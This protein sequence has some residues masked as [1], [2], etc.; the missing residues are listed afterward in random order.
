MSDIVYFLQIFIL[1]YSCSI[2][3]FN[4]NL[5]IF[6]KYCFYSISHLSFVLGLTTHCCKDKSTSWKKTPNHHHSYI[7]IK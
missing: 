6:Y 1:F 7:Y 3:N 4:F 2:L 5:F